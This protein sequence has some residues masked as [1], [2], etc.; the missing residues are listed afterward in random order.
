MAE[1]SALQGALIMVIEA[2]A[3]F[4]TDLAWSRDYAL[5]EHMA[6]TF[7]ALSRSA[8]GDAQQRQFQ[9]TVE[10][11]REIDFGRGATLSSIDSDAPL[12]QNTGICRRTVLRS[13]SL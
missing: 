13:R 11:L 7:Q 5:A 2:R 10:M 12:D 8:Y 9:A 3:E 6:S 1:P 4:G